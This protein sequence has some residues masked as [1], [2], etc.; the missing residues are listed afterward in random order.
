MPFQDLR[1]FLDVL[2]REGELLE[3]DRPMHLDNEIPYVSFGACSRNACLTWAARLSTAS[4]N[5]R[6]PA[7]AVARDGSP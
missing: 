2:Q 7:S 6:L 5:M 3:I 4:S 1:Q